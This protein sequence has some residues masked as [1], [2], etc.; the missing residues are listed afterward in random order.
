MMLKAIRSPVDTEW[1]YQPWSK[2]T[3]KSQ[4]YY[5]K[6]KGLG[7]LW[8]QVEIA[9]GSEESESTGGWSYVPSVSGGT[10]QFSEGTPGIGFGPVCREDQI[11]PGSTSR[12]VPHA[13]CTA[14]H[15]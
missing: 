4:A 13:T 11:L 2:G 1:F 3:D 10:H 8:F 12:G 14:T 15:S 6:S 7:E 5:A 9:A